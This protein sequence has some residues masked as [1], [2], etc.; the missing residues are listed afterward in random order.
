[1]LS[2]R[3]PI[4]YKHPAKTPLQLFLAG[5]QLLISCHLRFSRRA[6]TR[7]PSGSD[8]TYAELVCEGIRTYWEGFHLLPLSDGLK[9][10]S[11]RVQITTGNGRRAALV[12]VKRMFIMPAHV[13][14]PVHRLYWGLFKTGQLESIGTNWS[15][16]QPGTMI[17]P[18]M[19]DPEQVKRIAAHEAGH[20]F[21]I[22]DA[23]AAIY[24]FY[25]AAP[26]TGH[27]MMHSNWAVQ[28]EEVLMM[29]NAHV[30]GRMQFFP[31]SFQWRRF[32]NGFAEEIDQRVKMAES[33]MA[34]WSE[35]RARK[36]AHRQEDSDIANVAGVS[37]ENMQSEYNATVTGSIVESGESTVDNENGTL[38]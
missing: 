37:K 29:L 22:G 8:R 11:V 17:L 9:P 20:L 31:R 21:G 10:L 19:D 25:D 6:L 32:R 30:T 2:T 12:Q 1:M 34:Q 23:Y 4:R 13:R 33:Q 38:R 27:Y 14:S 28:P 15:L 18:F 7:C 3:F 16:E 24:R 26:G 5:D 35:A 36:R